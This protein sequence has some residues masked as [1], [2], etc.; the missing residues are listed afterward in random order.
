[1][2]P[3]PLKF[4]RKTAKKT[5]KTTVK[6]PIFDLPPMSDVV[7]LYLFS[8]QGAEEGLVGFIN[9]VNLSAGRPL[10]VKAE[11]KSPLYIRIEEEMN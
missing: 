11:I 10:I 6:K 5:A 1:M 4:A 2:D 3:I 8:S 9:A 7:F